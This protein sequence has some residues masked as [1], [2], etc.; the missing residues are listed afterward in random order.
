MLTTSFS[1]Q[2][3]SLKLM[4]SHEQGVITRINT[5]CDTTV[6]RLRTMGLMPGLSIT[7]EQRSPRFIVQVGSNRHALDESAIN[8]VYVR[9][10]KH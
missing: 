8:A 3:A 4:R 10:V 6:Q 2:E 1:I 7:V 9:F 5:S